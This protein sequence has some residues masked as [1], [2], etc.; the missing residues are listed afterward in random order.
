MIVLFKKPDTIKSM[1]V[2]KVIK[3]VKL[4]LIMSATNSVSELSFSFLKRIKTY[5]RST[6]TNNQ[7]N[8]LLVLHIHKLLTDSI[9]WKLL[10]SSLREEKEENQDLDFVNVR[11]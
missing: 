4:I 8:D 7:L 6:T 11:Y 5:L 1:L 2:A 10:T 3:L 9:L